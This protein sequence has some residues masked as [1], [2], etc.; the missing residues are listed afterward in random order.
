M[1]M[2]PYIDPRF[3]LLQ[4]ILIAVLVFVKKSEAG[5]FIFAASVILFL[6]Y[7]REV[8]GALRFGVPYALLSGVYWGLNPFSYIPVIST[9]S[10]LVFVARMVTPMLGAYYLFTKTVTVNEFLLSLEKM[11][12]PKIVVIP[13]AVALRFFP[14]IGLEVGQIK[15]ALRI[16]NHPLTVYTVLRYPLRMME[17]VMV[18]LM[19]RCIRIGDELSA[20]AVARGIENPVPRTSI[21]SL[22]IGAKDLFFLFVTIILLALC[23]TV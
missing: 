10:I 13:L 8:K 16:R 4:I 14:T 12:M 1:S 19:M 20:S 7:H 11:Y 3:R 21:R 9:I 23:L 17:Y 2:K 15:D 22:H 18:P 6:L 5:N